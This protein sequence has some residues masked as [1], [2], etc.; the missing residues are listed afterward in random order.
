MMS[1][2]DRHVGSGGWTDLVDLQVLFFRLTL[3]SATEFL[4]G[5]SV[6]SQIMEADNPPEKSSSLGTATGK[7]VNFAKAIDS[8]QLSLSTAGRLGPLYWLFHTK[9]FRNNVSQCHS[10]IDYFVQ[11]ALSRGRGEKKSTEDG[12]DGKEKYV[13]LHALAE[14]TQDPVELRSQLLNILLAGRDT[15]AS[16]L[17]WFFYLMAQPEHE[18]K[19]QRLRTIV[20]DEFGTYSN[21]KNI[22]FETLKN[23][24]YLQ[25][26]INETLRLYPI[27]PF[28]A[29]TAVVDTSLPTGGGKDGR[30]PLY[31]K[32]GEDVLYSVSD[33]RH[34]NGCKGRKRV[35]FKLTHCIIGAPH[36]SPQR[37]LG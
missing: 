30:S 4:F 11:S 7:Q 35:S 16:T 6:D 14:Q 21:P 28:N 33:P 37:S 25:W 10:F 27:V 31:V 17:G 29:R 8:S 3:D 19:Y 2:L 13:F 18:K 15:T 5:E 26:C 34:F 9:D 22:T 36:A 20:L 24:Q 1:V 32:K 12:V 23:S